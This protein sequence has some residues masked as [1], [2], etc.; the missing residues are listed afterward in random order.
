MGV[1]ACGLCP[2]PDSEGLVTASV[3]KGTG[4][5]ARNLESEASRGALQVAITTENGNP[6]V[7]GHGTVKLMGAIGR[8]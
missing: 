5:V 4:G 6:L 8:G 1:C 7:D 3:V 2:G